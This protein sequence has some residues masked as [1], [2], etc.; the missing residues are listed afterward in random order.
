M[1]SLLAALPSLAARFDALPGSLGFYD[2]FG[3]EACWYSPEESRVLR[4]KYSVAVSDMA[5]IISGFVQSLE[6]HAATTTTTMEA[7]IGDSLVSLSPNAACTRADSVA[8]PL[9]QD[10]RI[11]RT[12]QMARTCFDSLVASELEA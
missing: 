10:V 4:V 1:R 8:L 6:C 7:P 11:L 5:S 3:T 9:A 2:G 12:L